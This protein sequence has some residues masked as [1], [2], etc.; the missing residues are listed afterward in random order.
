MLNQTTVH[1]VLLALFAILGLAV[2]LVLLNKIYPYKAVD[3]RVDRSQAVQIATEYL[4]NLR[5]DL[6][7]YHVTTTTRYNGDAFAYLQQEL[8]LEK[9]VE[10]VQGEDANLLGYQWRIH[11]FK[12]LPKSAPQELFLVDVSAHGEVVGFQR[13]IPENINWP[14]PEKAHLSREEA[15][16]QAAQFLKVQNIDISDYKEDTFTSQRFEKRTD[17]TFRW[18]KDYEKA[19]GNLFHIIKIQGDKVGEYFCYYELPET[20]AL[21]SKQEERAFRDYFLSGIFSNFNLSSGDLYQK[22]S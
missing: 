7:D 5:Y 20:A 19:P 12:N 11:W 15:Y 2:F 21:E 9:T 14:R 3:F 17:H 8:G 18:R 13:Q 6:Q 4:Q 10:I 16:Q 1:K 22:I